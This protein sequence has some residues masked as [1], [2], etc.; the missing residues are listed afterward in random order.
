MS[1]DPSSGSA[2]REARNLEEALVA[3]GG[4]PPRAQ[5]ADVLLLGPPY[6]PRHGPTVGSY[7]GAVSY[8]QGTPVLAH[9]PPPSR[10]SGCAP[11]LSLKVFSSLGSGY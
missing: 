6:G 4:A 8:E 5:E 1:E 3:Q 10:G 2:G 9:A 7:G 11:H